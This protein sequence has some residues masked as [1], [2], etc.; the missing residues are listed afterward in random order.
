[1]GDVRGEIALPLLGP[2]PSLTETHNLDHGEKEKPRKNPVIM[3]IIKVGQPKLT[4]GSHQSKIS[5]LWA[6]DC[7]GPVP[8]SRRC[9]H[10]RPI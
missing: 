3:R 4:I 6:H 1:M 7:V 2:L 5:G 10:C 9:P 8:L